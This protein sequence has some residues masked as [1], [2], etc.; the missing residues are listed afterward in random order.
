MSLPIEWNGKTYDVDP[1]EF[2]MQE[3]GL[4]KDRVGLGYPELVMGALSGHGDA[5]RALFW[6]VDQREDPK[7]KF[8]SYP[9]PPGK[10][11]KQMLPHFSL[12]ASD[13]GKATDAAEE[14]ITKAG[15]AGSANST[16]GADPNSSGD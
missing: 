10:V 12:L 6:L 14:L 4:I 16:A 2:T 15:S 1:E 5:V 3:L 9:G 8:A 11:W 13:M 7:L